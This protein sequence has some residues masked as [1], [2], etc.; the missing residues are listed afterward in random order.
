MLH[1]IISSLVLGGSVRRRFTLLA[2]IF[3]LVAGL[4]S[5]PALATKHPTVQIRKTN[6]GSILVTGG[7]YTLYS[8]TKDTRNRDACVGIPG[9]LFVWPALIAGHPTAGPGVKR[10]LLGAIKVAGIG[11]QVTYAGHPLYTYVGDHHRGETD[12]VNIY[13]SGGYW[14]AIT[15]SGHAA[16]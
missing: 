9:C 16:R 11:R 4:A 8:F 14:P 3:L 15:A 7:G 1:H 12:N 10:R 13:Q 2:G 6:L 5:S